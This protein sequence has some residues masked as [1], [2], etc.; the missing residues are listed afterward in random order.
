MLKKQFLYGL[1]KRMKW[2][3]IFASL[4]IL[5][6]SLIV[7]AEPSGG[8]YGPIRQTYDLPE[9]SGKIYYVAPDGKAESSGETL[10]KPT[11]IEKAIEKVV[12]G[13]A[14]VVRGGVY[15]TGELVLNQGITIQAY[16]D[17][18]PVFV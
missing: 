10:Q 6:I 15:R 16:A 11:T 5:F 2:C 4:C 7:N 3:K 1:T 14:I 17:E 12:T 18:K 8:P 13:D 9:V